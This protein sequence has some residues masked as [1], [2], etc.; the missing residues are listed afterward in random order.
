MLT[1]EDYRKIRVA[2]SD[3]MS[4]RAIARKFHHSRRKIRQILKN[5]EPCPY[6]R[7]LFI[8]LPIRWALSLDCVVDFLA[9]DGYFGWGVYAQAYLTSTHIKDSNLNVVANHDGLVTMS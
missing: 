1:V 4:I 2:H 5:P 8:P 9:V 6:V 7:L 3:G